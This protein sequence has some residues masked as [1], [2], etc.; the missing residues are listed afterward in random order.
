VS[1][2]LLGPRNTSQLK[3]LYD[4]SSGKNLHPWLTN[5]SVHQFCY[6]LSWVLFSHT[7]VWSQWNRIQKPATVDHSLHATRKTNIRLIKLTWRF[8]IRVDLPFTCRNL[9]PKFCSLPFPMKRDCLQS[10]SSQFSFDSA[11]ARLTVCYL[12]SLFIYIYLYYLFISNWG[13]W[14][15]LWTTFHRKRR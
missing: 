11:C 4:V 6:P 15:Q 1:L 5:K 9:I 13:N 8:R 2:C 7:N 12:F 10:R 3:S 14:G